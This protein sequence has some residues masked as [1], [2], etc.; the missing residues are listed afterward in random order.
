MA[1]PR[2]YKAGTCAVR[3]Q[4]IGF[5]LHRLLPHLRHVHTEDG[6]HYFLLGMSVRFSDVRTAAFARWLLCDMHHLVTTQTVVSAI[7]SLV[8]MTPSDRRCDLELMS[9]LALCA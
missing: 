9:Y 5:S 4:D 7:D 2:G 1:H 6:V 3:F 8:A